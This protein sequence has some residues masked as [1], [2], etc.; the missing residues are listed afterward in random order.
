MRAVRRSIVALA[1]VGGAMPGTA[2][3]DV[4][5]DSSGRF[6]SPREVRGLACDD[7]WY[8]RNEIYARNDFIFI[9]ARGKAAFGT[10]GSTRNPR[11]NRAERANVAL[12]E[13]VEYESGCR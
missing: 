12:I 5:P 7:L 2:F 8:A 10:G 11:L 6:L 9:T 3:A 13:N 4:F 1:L